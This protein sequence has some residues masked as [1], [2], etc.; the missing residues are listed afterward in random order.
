VSMQPVQPK[1]IL[2][3]KLLKVPAVKG[4]SAASAAVVRLIFLSHTI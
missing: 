2:L 3:Y 1:N 4:L